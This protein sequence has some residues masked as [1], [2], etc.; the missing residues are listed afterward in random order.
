MPNAQALYCKQLVGHDI[1]QVFYIGNRTQQNQIN[2]PTFFPNTYRDLI[3]AIAPLVMAAIA[4]SV[5]LGK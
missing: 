4:L 1:T 3:S 5:A 2:C